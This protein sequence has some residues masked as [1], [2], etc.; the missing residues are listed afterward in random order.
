MISKATKGQGAIQ[1]IQ[2]HF[3]RN[4][5]VSTFYEDEIEES[6]VKTEFLEVFAK[7]ILNV[8]KRKGMPLE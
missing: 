3:E 4:Q 7:T 2:N 8:V 1:N 5:L 6:T